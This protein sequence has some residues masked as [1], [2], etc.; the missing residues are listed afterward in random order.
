MKTIVTVL[1]LVFLALLSFSRKPF[2]IGFASGGACGFGFGKSLRDVQEKE[3]RGYFMEQLPK[4]IDIES[5]S[6]GQLFDSNLVATFHI[7]Q[8]EAR[9]LVSDLEATFHLRQNH[10]TFPDSSKRREMIGP[11]A[12]T[13]HIYYLPGAPNMDMR[14]VSVTLPADTNKVSTVV[15]RGTR[16]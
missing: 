2:E 9:Q 3:I 16:F 4:S 11:P 10:S 12:Y 14:T 1:L 6:C 13:T 7:S 15:Y 5:V 8:D